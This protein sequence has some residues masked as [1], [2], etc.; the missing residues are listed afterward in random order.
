MGLLYLGSILRRNG[1]E[2]RL[3]DCL[4]ENEEKRKADGRAPFIMER[5]KNPEPLGGVRKRF[6]RYGI[7]TLEVERYL[8]NSP[9]P[10]LV[11]VTSM[12]TY[13]YKGAEEILSTVRAVFPS[14]KIV[15]GGVYASLCHDH[16]KKRMTEADLVAGADG[17]GSLYALIEKDLDCTLAFKPRLENFADF[18]Y[19]LF[20]LYG[21]RRF[22]PLLT[23]LGCVFRC[24][25][26]A[27]SYLYPRLI[28]RRVEGVIGE[29]HHWKSRGISS[30]ALYDDS[31]L[32]DREGFAKPLLEAIARLPFDVS[33]HNPNALNAALI[34]SET[35]VLLKNAGFKEVRMGLEM[36]DPAEQASTGGKVSKRHFEEAVG[37]LVDAGFSPASIRAYVL[38]GLP[39][40]KCEEVKET[41]DYA[42]GLG[43]QVSLAE[44]TPIPHT[45]IFDRFHS[46][47]RY[48]ILEEPMFQNNSL[49][50]FEW[51]GFTENDLALL[52]RYVRDRN[53]CGRDSLNAVTKWPS[54]R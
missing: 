6:K 28:S 31:F 33:I 10:D 26:C 32:Q 14:A 40:Q 25:Y 4:E 35:A 18:P 21:T 17:L 11:L 7:P 52:K 8:S 13:W 41:A 34:D 24:T 43:V 42:A 49:F 23:S 53:A 15:V 3:L 38:A 19:P 20:D 39:F 47:A 30:F 5:V 54:D 9:P 1:M 2:V 51:E 16:A 46:F 12:M 50:P 27:T 29:M 37:F 45:P 44:Y 22:V 36:V 48:P